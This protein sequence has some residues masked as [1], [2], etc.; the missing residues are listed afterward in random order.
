MKIEKKIKNDVKEC[1]ENYRLFPDETGDEQLTKAQ[2]SIRQV[3]LINLIFIPSF[4][5]FKI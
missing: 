1:F 3:R 5:F 4:Y 2:D